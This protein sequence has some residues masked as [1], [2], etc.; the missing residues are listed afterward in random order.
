MSRGWIKRVEEH[1][2]QSKT[3]R[4]RLNI[5]GAINIA[6][7]SAQARFDDAID[8]ES[9]IALFKQLEAANPTAARI[10]VICNSCAITSPVWLLNT[11]STGPLGV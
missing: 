11:S 4:R 1:P 5:N 9:T 3:G 7:L 8:A 2:I 10:I 6:T